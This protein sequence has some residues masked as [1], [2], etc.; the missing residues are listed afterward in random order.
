VR[1]PQITIDMMVAV[2]ALAHKKTFEKAAE[3][4]GTIESSAV[5]KRVQA[6]NRLFGA[7]LFFNSAEGMVL[8]EAGETFYIDAVRAVE[9]TL[10][11]EERVAAQ[12][13]LEKGR[14]RIGHSTY[15]PPKL[16]ASVLKLRLDRS[17][18]I[19]IEHLSGLTDD[20]AK[21][22][23]DGELHAGFGYLPVNRPALLSRVLW[24][25]PLEVF[26]AASHRLALRHGIR[27]ADLRDEPVIAVARRTMPWLYQE[28]DE[29]FNGFGVGLHVVADALGPPEALT[30]TEQKVGI[31]LL[32]ASASSRAG[33]MPRP[34]TP[35]IL[36]R[37][38]G[39]FVR[40]DNRH[41]VVKELVE[42]AVGMFSGRV[43]KR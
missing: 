14:L 32:G 4:I 11:A 3:E 41:P 25:E 34:I 39:I 27:A 24:E 19:Q 30:M 36:T 13:N 20:I 26:M 29:F 31:C 1:V 9:Q 10:L 6:V 38:S 40:E 16:L 43:A 5:F 33:V 23:V 8:T 37:K 21:C 18:A 12:L 22:V 2:I 7:P 42:K 17:P 15:L 35:R 28:I